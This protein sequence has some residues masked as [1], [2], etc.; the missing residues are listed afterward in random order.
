MNRKEVVT[1]L[2]GIAK[3]PGSSRSPFIC[4]DLVDQENLFVLQDELMGLIDDLDHNRAVAEL[5]F[6][7]NL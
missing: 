4:C 1:R 3:T 2:I 6:M 5:P 7:F